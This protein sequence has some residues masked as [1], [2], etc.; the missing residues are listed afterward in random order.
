M[1]S[2]LAGL[3]NE[4]AEWRLLG[5]LFEYPAGEW[6]QQVAA[7]AGEAADPLLRE[8]ASVALAEA[9]AG[10]HHSILGP[11]GPAPAREASYHPGVQLG[12][13]MA[14]ISS[15]YESFGYRPASP[16]PPDH[17][18]VEAGFI[19]YLKLK[20]VYAEASGRG[21]EASL[22]RQAVDYFTREHLSV[23]A[24]PLAERL[25][26]AA[27]AWLALAGRAL[28]ERAGP[29]EAA[30]A[31]HLPELDEDEL[32]CAAAP[33]AVSPLIQIPRPENPHE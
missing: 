8:A 32:T 4:S 19:A 33:P 11:G 6:R 14:E 21:D 30:P 5:L 20:Q 18:A 26:F 10:A 7:L 2:V 24:A 17:V 16:E 25:E 13:L 9:T 22:C 3:L 23:I 28:L 29:P 31:F 15:V 1:T 27:P 12:Y